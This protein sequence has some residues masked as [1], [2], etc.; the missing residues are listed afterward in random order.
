MHI[1]LAGIVCGQWTCFIYA[2]VICICYTTSQYSAWTPQLN[3]EGSSSMPDKQLLISVLQL[4]YYVY[5]QNMRK[6][7]LF[8]QV[9]HKACLHPT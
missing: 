2:T 3:M 4:S 8:T 6:I 1:P 9:G 5:K 7:L